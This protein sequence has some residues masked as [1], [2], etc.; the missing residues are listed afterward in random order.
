MRR[1]RMLVASTLLA[2]ALTVGVAACG[3]DEKKDGGGDGGNGAGTVA[4]T[5]KIAAGTE[6]KPGVEAL[7]K[8]Y[9]AKRPDV[10]IKTSYAIETQFNTQ[11]KAQLTGNN[12]P[13]VLIA[14]PG[15][16]NATSAGQLARAGLLQD[17]SDEPWVQDIN[18]AQLPEVTFDGATYMYPLG[19]DPMGIVYDAK[20]WQEQGMEV[21]ETWSDLLASCDAW[22][23]KGF[24]P[25]AVG[26]KES[27]VPQ[28]ITYALIASTVYREDPEFDDEQAAGEATFSDSGWREA[29]EKYV[30]LEKAGCFHKGYQGSGYDEM[31]N[32][33]TGGKAAMT[34]TVSASMGA[35]R[36][37]NPDAEIT[38][39][40]FPTTDNPEDNWV[41]AGVFAGF[42][43]SANSQNPDAA[44]DFLRFINT[45]EQAAKFQAAAGA[46]PPGDNPDAPGLERVV[47]VIQDGRTGPFPDHFWPNADVQA[48]HNA[49]VQQIFTGQATID[50][51]L[52]QMDD[53]YAKGS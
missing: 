33:V 20:V 6:I 7:I 45:P 21:P 35:M 36:E 10:E 47:E 34:V 51:A 25:I 28:F 17:L 15:S 18:E 23:E 26:M 29:L 24:E 41:G 40:P 42:V 22:R 9:Q 32:M 12:G 44:R 16:G 14:I 13:D 53:A 8:G 38:M 48:T 19:Y 50:E 43:M 4:G 3:D 11:I 46:V 37:S 52:Q 31:L 39:A 30:E 27:F 1:W 5:L 49:V 2:F